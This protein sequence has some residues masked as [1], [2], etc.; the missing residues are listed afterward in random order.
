[1]AAHR[2]DVEGVEVSHQSAHMLRPLGRGM[3]LLEERDKWGLLRGSRQ[4]D[5]AEACHRAR[6]HAPCGGSGTRVRQ[7]T[8]DAQAASSA[9]QDQG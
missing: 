9:L 1:M 6:G 4:L 2:L 3:P 5:K 8:C 7:K